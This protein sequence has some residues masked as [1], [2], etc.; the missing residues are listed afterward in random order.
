MRN[1]WMRFY[2]T[3]MRYFQLA[4][5]SITSRLTT[6]NIRMFW[7]FIEWLNLK[8]PAYHTRNFIRGDTTR[9]THTMAMKLSAPLVSKEAVKWLTNVRRPTKCL[10][11]LS[12]SSSHHSSLVFKAPSGESEVS[13]LLLKSRAKG[14]NWTWPLCSCTT[15]RGSMS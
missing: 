13:D 4:G 14:T 3:N 2:T 5:P 12:L 6:G 15:E 10:A 8:H 1:I 11:F 9:W 7:T